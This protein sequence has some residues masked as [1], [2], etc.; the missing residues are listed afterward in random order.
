MLNMKY[1]Y[2]NTIRDN[3]NFT[4]IKPYYSVDGPDL[5][6]LIKK[7]GP[8]ISNVIIIERDKDGHNKF[9]GIDHDKFLYF[10]L[11]ENF[12]SLNWIESVL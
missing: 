11:L 10:N 1:K 7:H 3:I 9:N 2:T 12:D 5:M 4:L 8:E 6:E